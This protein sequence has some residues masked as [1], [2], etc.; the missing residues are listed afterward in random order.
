[1]LGGSRAS[2][3][4]RLMDEQRQK[5]AILFGWAARFKWCRQRPLPCQRTEA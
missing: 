3:L 1:M 5:G 4:E 2:G